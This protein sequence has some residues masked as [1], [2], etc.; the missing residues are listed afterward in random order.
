M[1]PALTGLMMLA[2]TVCP[3]GTSYQGD[4]NQEQLSRPGVYISDVVEGSFAESLA[5]SLS[6]A[7]LPG[8]PP[9]TKG[10]SITIFKYRLATDKAL[11][12]WT[13]A[14]GCAYFGAFV[15]VAILRNHLGET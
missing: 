14:D 1:M 6:Y 10:G 11:L 2:A 9:L 15:P 5:I 7:V 13:G 3:A 12:V 4:I 8:A